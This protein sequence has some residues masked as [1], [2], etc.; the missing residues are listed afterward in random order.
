MRRARKAFVERNAW[1]S[2]RVCY[3]DLAEPRGDPLQT[4]TM[5]NDLR[6]PKSSLLLSSFW[7]IAPEKSEA[8]ALS[9]GT[10][11]SSAASVAHSLILA[12][13]TVRTPENS[14]TAAA[15]TRRWNV[16]AGA[17]S[18]DHEARGVVQQAACSR[19]TGCGFASDRN[20]QM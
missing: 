12:N 9:I 17:N 10:V 1:V 19:R 5:H 7:R 11:D 15:E 13:E 8:T 4:A 14:H 6:I 20:S 18:A 2:N 16:E 3:L